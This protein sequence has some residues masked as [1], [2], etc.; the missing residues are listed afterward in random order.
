MIRR[1][2]LLLLTALAAGLSAMAG[3]VAQGDPAEGRFGTGI[4][5]QLSERDRAAAARARQLDL[6]EQATK[7]AERRLAG[8]PSPAAP[9]PPAAAKEPPAE[10]EPSEAER[11]DDL[12]KIY[13]SM[14]PKAAAPIFEQLSLEVQ[15]KVAGRMRERSMAQVMAAMS[16]KAAAALTM[17]IAKRQTS[18]TVLGGSGLSSRG[19]PPPAPAARR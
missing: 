11:L 15:V 10:P 18:Y 17:A 12:A 7:A 8:S 13:Q 14:K 2:P 1:A 19:S 6:R 5:Q 4:R 9:R 16:P 3:A